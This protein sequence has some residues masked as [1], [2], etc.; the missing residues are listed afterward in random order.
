[1]AKE[2]VIQIRSIK[3]YF[4][5][6]KAVDGIDLS[7]A[8]AEFLALLGPNGAGKT[9]LVEMI[10]GLQKPDSGEILIMNRHWKGN[11]NYLRRLLGIS[12]QE[13]RFIDKLTTTETLRLFASFYGIGEKRIAEILELIRLQDKRKAYTVNLSGGQRQRLALGI[14]LMNSPS[15]L[16]LDEPTSGLDPNSRREIWDILLNLKKNQH[17]TMI[18][19]THY[20]EEAAFLCDKIVIMDKG[21]ILAEG[22][23]EELLTR[24]QSDE[25]IE[26][27]M[28][29]NPGDLNLDKSSWLKKVHFDPDRKKVTLYVT[30]II[31]ALPDILDK[32]TAGKHK[33]MGLEC[34]KMTL[35]DLF[36]SLT[37]R[38]LND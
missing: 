34:R 29:G 19:T 12:L 17:T 11:E 30:E 6:V 5:D 9:T 38:R 10:E 33:I 27:Y 32:S 21:R 15:V 28:E 7:I 35:D 24:N 31:K 25:I 3:K 22:A 16:L 14:A 37:G 8:E 1:L 23:L 26:F 20:M 13:T 18:L 36:I 2:P 4:R